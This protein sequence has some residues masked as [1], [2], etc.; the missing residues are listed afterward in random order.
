MS[1]KKF[2]TS[3]V[4]FKNLA[5]ALVI[6]AISVFGVMKFL[7]VATNHGEEIPVP[8]LAKMSLEKAEERL[9][10]I[11][12]ELHLLD[13]VD[14]NPAFPPYSIVEQDPLPAVTVKDGRKVYV[15]INSGGYAKVVLP[16]LVQK[17]YRQALS[18]LRALG[19]QEG[20]VKYVEYM[21]KD[22]VLEVK[23][24]GKTLKAGDKILK[25]SKIDFV[26]GDGKTGFQDQEMD[27]INASE[28]LEPAPAEEENAE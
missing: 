13:T 21:A 20:D 8:N 22:V 17:T 10:D 2:L 5:L 11:D 23:Q 12:L 7:S 26:L 4:F 19:L 27:S 16:E 9:S 28:Q 25:S 24:N 6:V 15:K 14:Y 1:W 3:P 18:T